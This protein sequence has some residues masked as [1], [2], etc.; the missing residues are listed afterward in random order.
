MK[1]KRKMKYLISICIT[2]YKRIKELNRCLNSVN[3][4]YKDK[5]EIVVSEDC[6]PQKDEIR[7]MVNEFSQTSPFK[8]VFNSNDNNLGYDRN[9]KKLQELSSGE[10]IFYLSDDDVIVSGALDKLVEFIEQSTNKPGLIYGSFWY[11]PISDMRRKHKESFEI[12]SGENS[13]SK[14]VYDAILFSGLIFRR[15]CIIE[16]HADR[17]KNLNYF[18]VYMFLHVIEKYGGY[19]LDEVMIDSVS[20]GENAYGQVES[21]KAN[22][23]SE[24]VDLANRDSVFSNLEFNKGLFKVIKIFDEDNGTSVF[25]EFSKEYSLRSFGGL[26]R[27]RSYGIKTF[28]KYWIK[29]HEM[30]MDYTKIVHVYYFVLLIFGS[31]IGEKIFSIP[32]KALRKIRG[33]K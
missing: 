33:S 26:C 9:L 29:L 5:V 18:Q 21:S 13:A 8:V 22:N 4:K 20:D 19:Y 23:H 17:F 1:R 10:Y 12:V 3:T 30:D 24:N 2:S 11:G 16:L 7:K 28:K 15:D 31:K 6:S 32:R 25:A 14:Y 27:A